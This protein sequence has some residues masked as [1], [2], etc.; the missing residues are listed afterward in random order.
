MSGEMVDVHAVVSLVMFWV[1]CSLINT[2]IWW[3]LTLIRRSV[4]PKKQRAAHAKSSSR[5]TEPLLLEWNTEPDGESGGREKVWTRVCSFALR[6][7]QRLLQTLLHSLSWSLEI[8]SP[9]CGNSVASG[10]QE[11]AGRVLNP[12]H[13]TSKPTPLLPRAPTRLDS[14]P[15]FC[16]NEGGGGVM[17]LR[18]AQCPSETL[19]ERP[20]QIKR[21]MEARLKTCHYHP[22]L[23]QI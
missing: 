9:A 10:G 19:A 11:G 3:G 1:K 12:L 7:L 21:V 6:V 2:L 14:L 8:R 13:S 22:G 4:G 20:F 5:Q 15:C 16:I 23:C 18:D 17:A